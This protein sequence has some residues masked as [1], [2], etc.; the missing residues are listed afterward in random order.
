MGDES[1]NGP[2]PIRASIVNPAFSGQ[3]EFF[4]HAITR[5]N[6]TSV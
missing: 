5:V 1:G 3:S 4:H 2:S 6:P